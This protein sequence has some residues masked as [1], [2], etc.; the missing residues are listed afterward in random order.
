MKELLAHRLRRLNGGMKTAGT[1]GNKGLPF[2]YDKPDEKD[3]NSDYE[4]IQH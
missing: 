3:E 4:R 1:G 2:I